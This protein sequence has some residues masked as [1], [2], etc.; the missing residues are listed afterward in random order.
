MTTYIC[1]NNISVKLKLSFICK[2]KQRSIT[3]GHKMD[4]LLFLGFW[5]G[6]ALLHTL[7]DLKIKPA[8]KADNK[9][10]QAKYYRKDNN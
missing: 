8:L 3:E 4:G 7:Y 9:V 6:G 10:E 5:I 1:N 2:F